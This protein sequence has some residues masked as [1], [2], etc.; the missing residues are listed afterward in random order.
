MQATEVSEE[1]A[2]R[3]VDALHRALGV[4]LAPEDALIT[5][6]AR[7]GVD[8]QCNLAMSLGK[9]LGRPPREVA[10]LI[11][12]NLDLAGV[13]EPPEVAGPGFLNF[14]LRREWLERSV[15]ALV[16]DERLGVAPVAGPRR[17]ALDYSS[18]NV[19]KEMHVGHLR[20]SV[21]GDAIARLLRF[22]GHEVLPHNHLG[23][24]GTPFGLLI[25]H[26]LDEP[27]TGPS[28]IGDLNAFYQAAR[29]KFDSD[30]AFATRSRERVV[31]LQGGD[32]GTLAVWQELVD[33]STRHFNEVYRQLAVTL[34][35]A[36]IYGES[37]YNPY[38]AKVVDELAADGLTEVS[39]GAVCVF[40][41][42]FHNREGDRLP[43]IVRKRDGGY[44][45]AATDLATAKYW[46]AERGATDL[47]YV[48]GTPQAQH[49]AM[50]FAV[51]RA[52]GWLD[53][54]RTE[55][56]GFGSVLGAD[57]KVMRTRAGETTKLADLLEEAVGQAAA[58]VAERSELDAG[59]QREVARAVGIGAVKY[60]DLSGDREHDYV[61]AWDRMLAKD[62][63][64]SVYLQYA[65]ARIESILAKA[66]AQPAEAPVLLGE[67]AERALALSLLRFGEAF[68]AAMAGYAPHK[69][70]A[71]LYETA[72]TFSRFYEQCPVLAAATPELRASRVQLATLT[73]RTLVLGL[74]LLGIEAPRRL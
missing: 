68:R 61:F 60:A 71:Y 18:P 49:F 56:I 22:A 45:Y 6:S 63:N 27:P 53:G 5:V 50:V 58:V 21:I 26:L 54:V 57:G 10:A 70:C 25:E 67:P 20:S 4:E 19:A 43:L 3:V 28:G 64:T 41:Q 72:V 52:A 15:C 66:G 42:G 73:A 11:V 74:D 46:T 33:E 62:G 55:H 47:L 32:A 31:K 37:F 34:T 36:D 13:A 2:R 9:R 59:E 17:I 40:P 30:E 38:L 7:E 8:Y 69:L 23:D 16:G 39:D 12:A 1:L 51:G 24:W 14:V 29:R 35:D 65:H 44:G 48:V